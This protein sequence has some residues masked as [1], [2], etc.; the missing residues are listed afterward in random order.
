MPGKDFEIVCW[1]YEDKAFVMDEAC[2]HVWLP[3]R[4]AADEGLELLAKWYFE[5]RGGP[6]QIVYPP[7]LHEGAV[8]VEV[9][10]PMRLFASA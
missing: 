5:G 8:G 3:V 6:V 4:E 2:A 9:Q 1:T 7:V 10:T